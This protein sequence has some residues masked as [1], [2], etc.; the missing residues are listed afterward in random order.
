MEKTG[1]RNII[2]RGLVAVI[3]LVIAAA[4]SFA[5]GTVLAIAHIRPFHQCSVC[6]LCGTGL[7]ENMAAIDQQR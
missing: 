5:G 1:L 7:C 2:D 4:V 6:D 3:V